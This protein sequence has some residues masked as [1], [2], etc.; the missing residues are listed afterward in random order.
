[1]VRY[2]ADVDG[3]LLNH[4]TVTQL[5]SNGLKTLEPNSDDDEDEDEDEGKAG[6]QHANISLRNSPFNYAVSYWLKHAMDVPSGMNSTSRSKALWELVKNL[7]W[8]N[9]GTAFSKWF[10]IFSPNS[11]DWHT[12]R[13]GRRA[14]CLYDGDYKSEVSSCLH[15]VASY[16][17]SD[18]LEWAHPE[19]L[20]FDIKSRQGRTPLMYAAYVGEID[21]VK[22]I[23]SKDGVNVNLTLCESSDC[24]GGHRYIVGT[25]LGHAII[26]RSP[27]TTE[28]LLKQPGIEVDYVWHGITALGVAINR[29]FPEEIRLLI[30]AGAKLAMWNGDVLAIPS[31]S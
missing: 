15:V 13:P 25:A 29:N 20:D 11:G 31:S 21:A 18:I 17:L 8:D 23:L 30:G 19:E 12:S 9:S 22:S 6:T 3:I 4:T 2:S 28:L 10:R 5:F 1:V 24:N 16:G 7:F 14:R 26:S 27:E